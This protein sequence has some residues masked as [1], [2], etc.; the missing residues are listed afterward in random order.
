MIAADA[1]IRGTDGWSRNV[2]GRQTSSRR[3][4]FACPHFRPDDECC[5]RLQTDCVPGRA[6]C[7]LGGKAVF[8]VPAEQRVRE[9]E[10]EKR[11]A[12]GLAPEA[13]VQRNA[14]G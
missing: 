7:V 2:R 14:G 1:A 8:A 3:M 13:G 11:L 12:P 5:L 6:G 10:E 9:R 4:S